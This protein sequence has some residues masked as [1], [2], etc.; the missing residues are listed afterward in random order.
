MVGINIEYY[1][2]D[3]KIQKRDTINYEE[4]DNDK[5]L[6]SYYLKKRK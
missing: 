3:C 6:Y 5:S 2:I 1:A 4:C